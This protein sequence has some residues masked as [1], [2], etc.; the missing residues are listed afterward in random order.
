MNF[1]ENIFGYSSGQK[2]PSFMELVFSLSCLQT[3]QGV[4][5][6]SEYGM[7]QWKEW[8]DLKQVCLGSVMYMAL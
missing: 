7:E 8:K 3:N 1:L 6:G 4:C 5:G 2:I